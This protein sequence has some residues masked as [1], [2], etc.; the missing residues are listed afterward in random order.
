[1]LFFSQERKQVLDKHTNLA[2][3]LL[4][5]IKTRGIDALYNAE[6]DA[7]GGKPDAAALSKLLQVCRHLID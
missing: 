2:T 1:L 5:E 7:L 3:A 4:Q 6:E